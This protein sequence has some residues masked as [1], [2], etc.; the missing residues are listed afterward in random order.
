MGPPPINCEGKMTSW[1][2][3]S[4]LPCML[5]KS[6]PTRGGSSTTRGGRRPRRGGSRPTWGGSELGSQH[7][8]QS[9][10]GGDR[11][12]ACGQGH[13]MVR[14]HGCF[15]YQSHASQ[16]HIDVAQCFCVEVHHAA[17]QELKR[18]QNKNEELLAAQGGL[19]ILTRD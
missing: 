10:R 16:P 7:L 13:E 17:K 14:R 4:C 5:P 11:R 12:Q 8:G 18:E 1:C 3:P 15:D 9:A 6:R 19:S 2:K